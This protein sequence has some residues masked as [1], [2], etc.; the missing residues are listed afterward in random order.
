MHCLLQET[1]I[2][3]RPLISVDNCTTYFS[4]G[5]ERKAG[6]CALVVRND[7]NNLVGGVWINVIK[8][9]LC[10]TAEDHNKDGFYGELNTLI[11]KIPSQQAVVVGVDAN[12]KMGPKQQSD[13][14]GKWCY[15]M[16]QTSDS[17]NRLTDLC[18]QTDLIITSTFKRNHRRHQLTWQGTTPS[19]S[20]VQRKRK[21]PTLSS[22]TF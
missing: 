16:E 22:T 17:G 18:E 20:E 10:T 14:L 3:D 1:L 8:M 15:P 21:M 2:W 19:T 4:D 6:G 9:R 13:V 11:N 5:D 12:A 7:Y